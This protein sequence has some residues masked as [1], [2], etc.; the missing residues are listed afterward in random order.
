MH[1]YIVFAA[2]QIFLTGLIFGAW[3]PFSINLGSTYTTKFE[4]I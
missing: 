1:P 2:K 3:V 4:K